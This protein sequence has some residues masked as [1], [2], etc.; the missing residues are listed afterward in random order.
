M[1]EFPLWGSVERFWN[2]EMLIIFTF[3]NNKTHLHVCFS[4]SIRNVG[5]L[6][7][8]LSP[9]LLHSAVNQTPANESEMSKCIVFRNEQVFKNLKVPQPLQTFCFFVE[10]HLSDQLFFGLKQRADHRQ[11]FD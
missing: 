2:N 7:D 11:P 8:I 3:Y 9:A 10:N 5:N 1:T 6:S 4:S